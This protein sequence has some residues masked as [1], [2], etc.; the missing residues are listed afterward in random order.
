MKI[1][2]DECCPTP[3]RSV[4]TEH[5]VWTVHSAAL[6]GITNGELLRAAE[7]RFEVLITADKNLRYQQDV[8]SRRIAIVEL[9]FNSW[10]RLAPLVGSI[11]TAL[12]GLFPGAYVEV[13]DPE[14]T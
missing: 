2:L 3:L 6:Q 14:R 10:K 8:S 5:E 7:Q 1:L 9:P 11:R 4:L 13:R 12:G